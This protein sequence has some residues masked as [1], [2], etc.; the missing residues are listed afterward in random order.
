MALS[1]A[2]QLAKE[3]YLSG[4][5]DLR[6]LMALCDG[7]D[8][9]QSEYEEIRAY[10]KNSDTGPISLEEQEEVMGE[11]HE[12]FPRNEEGEEVMSLDTPK[13]TRMAASPESTSEIV[14]LGKR[15]AEK[16]QLEAKKPVTKP[17]AEEKPKKAAKPQENKVAKLPVDEEKVAKKAAPKRKTEAEKKA[18]FVTAVKKAAEPKI[19][20]AKQLDGPDNGN[21]RKRGVRWAVKVCVLANPTMAPKDVLAKL[22][23]DGLQSKEGSTASIRQDFLVTLRA[24]KNL[25]KLSK[26][27]AQL[28][29]DGKGN[30]KSSTA[31]LLYN[32][33]IIKNPQITEKEL[34]EEMKKLGHQ[35]AG[36][37]S[38][39]AIRESLAVLR[40]GKALS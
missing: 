24:A 40:E 12:A 29:P 15:R 25:N 14:D 18:D 23:A 8:I 34:Y 9:S 4:Q 37:G 32:E 28:I 31:L 19:K 1:D 22:V 7:G 26:E 33:L 11:K 17:K 39:P 38:Y 36:Q 2:A 6:H 20:K 5:T 16:K 10:Q 35:T 13:R 21:G 3:E 27:L 30:R